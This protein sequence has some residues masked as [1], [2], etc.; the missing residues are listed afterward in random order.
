MKIKYEKF[1]EKICFGFFAL[2][3][4]F[5]FIDRHI[6]NI[7]LLLTLVSCLIDFKNLKKTFTIHYKLILSIIIFSL[8]ITGM[9]YYHS[10]PLHELDNYYRFL[11][12]L[13]ILLITLNESRLIKL[14]GIS[15]I[16][17]LLSAIFFLMYNE[18]YYRYSGTSSSALT[19]AY[20]CGTLFI[21]CAY[22]ILYQKKKSYILWIASGIFLLIYLMTGSRGPIIGIILGLMYLLYER[23]K[24]SKGNIQDSKAL[25][26]LSLIILVI[27][28]TSN[29]VSNR[30]D[31]ISEINI[32]NPMEIEESSLR[33]RFFYLSFGVKEIKN[34]FWTGIG[35]ENIEKKM[36][37][38]LKE[39]KIKH[40]T[41]RDHLHNGILDIV[42]KFGILSLLLLFN[43]Y[44]FLIRTNKA[45]KRVLL[46]TLIIMLIS[47]QL[48][49][50]QFAHHQAIS[51]F[52][53]LLFALQNY[54]NNF[55]KH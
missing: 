52:I 54:N 43:V 31:R 12:L 53:T 50:S 39:Q 15:A 35:P 8:Y 34:N 11:L 49:Q 33:E 29:P 27:F 45:D 21:L 13:P 14:L 4:C 40:I 38:H 30:L 25:M 23:F 41:P 48:F 5:N 44:Y 7:F 37:Q 36:S 17:A 6:A 42:S 28:F 18:N 10:S 16:S 22:Y 3:F 51:F 26:S 55:D 2:F 47:S 46:V 32:S 19:F 1:L 20:M 9:G 24:C